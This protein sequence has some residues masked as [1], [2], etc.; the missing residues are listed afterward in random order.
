MQAMTT[1]AP[2]PHPFPDPPPLC[3][4]D[5]LSRD[6]F[7]RRYAA[8]P[9]STRAELIEGI[10]Y[11]ASPARTEHGIPHAMVATW[12]GNYVAATPGVQPESS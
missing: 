2:R 1:L 3:S 4:G 5:H 7:E 11:V 8:M 9:E 12:L 10:V 6:E